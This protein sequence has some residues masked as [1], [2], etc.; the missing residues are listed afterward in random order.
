MFILRLPHWTVEPPFGSVIFA[1]ALAYM[2][3]FVGGCGRSEPIDSIVPI[4]ADGDEPVTVPGGG[5]M[6]PTEDMKERAREA[7][8]QAAKQAPIEVAR[9]GS[10]H[11][12]IPT[13]RRDDGSVTLDL[14]GVIDL[15][16]LEVLPN[17]Y[18]GTVV[19]N[20]IDITQDTPVIAQ[21]GELDAVRDAA[22][23]NFEGQI[24]IPETRSGRHKIEVFAFGKLQ[25]VKEADIP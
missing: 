12:V 8:A 17:D 10:V 2:L 16:D 19:I 5:K 15:A 22:Q 23:L 11:K 1:I 14:A 7:K 21:S 13:A 24:R 20:V 18:R 4:A 6:L 3:A 25:V 9:G